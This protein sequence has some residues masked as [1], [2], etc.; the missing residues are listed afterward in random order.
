MLAA[1]CTGLEALNPICQAGSIGGS[2]ASSGFESVLSGISQWVAS[3]AEWLLSQIGQVLS[4]TTTVDVADV[5]I[6]GNYTTGTSAQNCTL[7][8][9]AGTGNALSATG[10]SKITWPGPATVDSTSSS[11]TSASG[12]AVLSGGSFFGLG[13]VH[14]TGSAALKTSV[15]PTSGS[16][17][18]PF[19]W[20]TY[21]T[22]SGSPSTVSVSGSSTKTVSPGIYSN[23][24]VSGSGQLTLSPGVYIITGGLTI[25][26]AGKV[27]GTGVTLD[28]ECATFPSPCTSGGASLSLSGSAALTITGGAIGPGNGFALIADRANAGSLSESGNV[29]LS[30][31]GISYVPAMAISVT[32]SSVFKLNTGELVAGT[33]SVTGSS[34]ITVS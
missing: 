7:C 23:I 27:S 6:V 20:F 9:L 24:T 15:S 3:G 31:V 4:A 21:P 2:V 34:N 11:A 10:S 12:S 29:S 14:L 32:G 8:L 1:G 28:L 30:V 17:S 26:G 33:A 25:S 16:V 19:S 13:G 5:V 22:G 18:D